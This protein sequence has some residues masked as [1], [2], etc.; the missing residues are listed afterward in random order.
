MKVYL[1]YRNDA[2]EPVRI[3]DWVRKIEDSLS[4]ARGHEPPDEGFLPWVTESADRVAY[5]LFVL[6]LR[7]RARELACNREPLPA[8][9]STFADA[10]Q[11]SAVVRHGPEASDS[12]DSE[13]RAQRFALD[14]ERFS[15][16]RIG[17][18]LDYLLSLLQKEFMRTP[19]EEA[20]AKSTVH[21]PRSEELENLESFVESARERTGVIV[22]E[23]GSG[24]SSMLAHFAARSSGAFYIDVS[25]LGNEISSAHGRAQRFVE[26]DRTCRQSSLQLAK[27]SSQQVETVLEEALVNE[28][29]HRVIAQ[30]R[31]AVSQTRTSGPSEAGSLACLLAAEWHELP[32]DSLVNYWLVAMLVVTTR[33]R[34]RV[35]VEGQPSLD[36][37]ARLLDATVLSRE[38]RQL[39]THPAENL[40][41]MLAL[42]NISDCDG[43]LWRALY[44]AF[45]SLARPV[46]I[47]DNFER[48]HATAV[49]QPALQA[50]LNLAA[51]ISDD[52]AS[53]GARWKT[54][55]STRNLT[56]VEQMLSGLRADSWTA[57]SLTAVQ[58]EVALGHL[59]R[60]HLSQACRREILNRRIMRALQAWRSCAP[61]LRETELEA[62]A[63]EGISQGLAGGCSGETDNVSELLEATFESVADGLC[64]RI[65][66]ARPELGAS[67]PRARGMTKAELIEI[68]TAKQK[69]LPARDV[70]LALKQILEIMS[71]ALSAGE[72]IEIRGFG[73][74]SLHFR[75][76]RRE[77]SLKTKIK[78]PSGIGARHLK[79]GKHS[80]ENINND[81]KP[82]CG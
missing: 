41:T 72:R 18:Q 78:T 54:M 80:P 9:V 36:G 39:T 30:M 16:R 37:E 44:C 21:C 33:E 62:I 12:C 19:R 23:C 50:A 1:S 24:K 31:A 53:G 77:K 17:S 7:G 48:L 14:A 63:K 28:I 57:V 68:I 11:I 46:L 35:Q 55:I 40:D 3:H 20:V 10:E 79:T 34:D 69:H 15:R 32:V 76:P 64:T 13:S 65:L 73:S 51:E 4:H 29:R 66:E 47:L 25:R 27:V 81:L 59:Q 45:F 43:D 56:S 74:F 58:G 42:N 70:E 75:P 8:G 26:R 67:P 82:S 49:V 71:E 6:A 5:V 22:G 38:I 2:I 61:W 52:G 60:L